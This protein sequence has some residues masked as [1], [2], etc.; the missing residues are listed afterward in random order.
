MLFGMQFTKLKKY[1]RDTNNKGE[2]HPTNCNYYESK[3]I[4]KRNS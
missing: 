4:T 3:T 1:K 2:Q